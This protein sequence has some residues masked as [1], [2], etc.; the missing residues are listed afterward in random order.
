MGIADAPWVQ[1][2]DRAAWRAWL[3]AN[4]ATVRG[5]W[6]V[7]WRAGFGPVLAY[8]DAVEEALCF[9]WVDGQAGR[10]DDQHRKLYVARRNPRSSWA[11]SN[12]ER[13]ERLTAAGLMAE[14]GLAAVERARAD[15]TW[16]MLED[17]ENLVVPPDLAAALAAVPA[18]DEGWSAC[19]PSGRRMLLEW[20][21]QA[22][23]PETRAT[24]I[25]TIAGCA[26]HGELPPPLRPRERPRT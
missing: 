15:G 5:V 1:P 14:A 25:G 17:A 20:I 2:Q 22:K 13:V 12:R 8:E 26:G 6:L 24:R 23:R 18:A 4:H 7:T 19:S 21:R 16:T 11:R 3:E 9:G 10:V